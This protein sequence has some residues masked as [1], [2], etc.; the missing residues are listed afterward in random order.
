MEKRNRASEN[1]SSG[2]VRMKLM[3]FTLIELLVVIAIIAI[4]VQF[5]FQHLIPPVNAAVRPA[6]S[7]ISN[8]VLWLLHSMRTIITAKSSC[9][10]KTE[11]VMT[12]SGALF[13]KTVMVKQP[14]T[15]IRS[16]CPP[17]P[18]SVP[19]EPIRIKLTAFMPFPALRAYIFLFMTITGKKLVQLSNSEAIKVGN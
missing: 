5:C 6:A 14:G 18:Q 3:S 17:M 10:Q 4:L 12:I 11:V 8:S 16:I 15:K 7:T 2:R 13:L 9:R 1:I 19:A